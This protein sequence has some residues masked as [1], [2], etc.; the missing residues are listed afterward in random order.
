M[1]TETGTKPYN[2]EV[3]KWRDT[4]PHTRQIVLSRYMDDGSGVDSP[5]SPFGARVKLR[6]KL[7]KLR[8]DG[9]VRCWVYTN[10]LSVNKAEPVQWGDEENGLW[11]KI[12]AA[13][14][15]VVF[16]NA[17]VEI[18]CVNPPK[19]Q[20]AVRYRELPEAAM[21][22]SFTYQ[23]DGMPQLCGKRFLDSA[24]LSLDPSFVESQ[25]MSQARHFIVDLLKRP[26]VDWVKVHDEDPYTILVQKGEAFEWKDVQ[27]QVI[28]VMKEFFAN[29][30]DVKPFEGADLGA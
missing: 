29:E 23:L 5:T 22:Y 10:D 13:V 25:D 7:D 2:P 20:V 1:D 14:K 4:S 27:D 18:L 6:E 26:G 21:E 28:G 19:H 15:E 24:G 30:L 17:S 12:I 3:I 9:V 16:R 8:P 11:T